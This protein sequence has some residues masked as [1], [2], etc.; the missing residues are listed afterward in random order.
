MNTVL[1][2]KIKTMK[3]EVYNTSNNLKSAAI[4]LGMEPL[5]S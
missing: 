2:E 1:Y 5:D 4:S 3:D